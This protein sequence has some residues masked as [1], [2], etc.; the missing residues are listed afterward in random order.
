MFI[1]SSLVSVRQWIQWQNLLSSFARKA[2]Y[3]SMSTLFKRCPVTPALSRG[4]YSVYKKRELKYFL[5]KY[6][7]FTRT[8]LH[9]SQF[10]IQDMFLLLFMNGDGDGDGTHLSLFYKL[11]SG[12][13]DSFLLWPFRQSLQF[14]TSESRSRTVR[15]HSCAP[16]LQQNMLDI[17]PWQ[18]HHVRLSQVCTPF[19]AE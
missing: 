3:M 8:I 5:V 4:K 16:A 14:E 2:S 19:C 18:E 6:I 7:D 11:I 12:D 15:L 13:Y 10:Y 17:A 1:H 9:W